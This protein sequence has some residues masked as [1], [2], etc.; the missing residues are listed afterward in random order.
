MV[1]RPAVI[2]D[3]SA[4]A[5]LYRVLFAEMAALQPAVWRPSEMPRSFILELITGARSSVLLV[6]EAGKVAGFAVVQDRDTPQLSCLISNRY[7]YLMDMVVEPSCRGRGLGRALLRAAERWARERELKWMELN[8][9]EENKGAYNLYEE[10]GLS[11]AQHTMRKML[12]G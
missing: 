4:I 11:P 7:C 1:I 3:M 5:A 12:D 2:E 6:E 10:M 8:V 9:L